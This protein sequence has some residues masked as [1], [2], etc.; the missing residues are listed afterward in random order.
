MA[1]FPSLWQLVISMLMKPPRYLSLVPGQDAILI[2]LFTI[3]ISYFEDVK[4]IDA[5][6]RARVL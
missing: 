2:K 1:T 5:E 3:F 6:V 4:Y